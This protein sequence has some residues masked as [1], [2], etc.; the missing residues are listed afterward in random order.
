MLGL[1]L[2]GLNVTVSWNL[3]SETGMGKSGDLSNEMRESVT[4]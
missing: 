3:T 1:Y 2:D 4:K